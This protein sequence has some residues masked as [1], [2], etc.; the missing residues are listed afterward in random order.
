MLSLPSTAPPNPNRMRPGEDHDFASPLNISGQTG[1]GSSKENT[2]RSTF[3][4]ALTPYHSF[5]TVVNWPFQVKDRMGSSTQSHLRQDFCFT[6]IV[7]YSDHSGFS[8][9]ASSN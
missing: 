4:P 6:S 2:R 9:K 8:G 3:V 7:R 1:D 5:S